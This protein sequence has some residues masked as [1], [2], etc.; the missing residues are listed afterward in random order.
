MPSRLLLLFLLIGCLLAGCNESAVR[1]QGHYE[2]PSASIPADS[3]L[4]WANDLKTGP[5]SQTRDQQ[6]FSAVIM[7]MYYN[8]TG[9]YPPA[10]QVLKSSLQ[11]QQESPDSSLLAMTNLMLGNAAKNLGE[12][13]EALNL[14]LRAL[15][16]YEHA[17]DKPS[18]A[19]VHAEIG[20][21]F[22]LKDDLPQ[23]TLHLNTALRL[24]DNHKNTVTYLVAL[25]T[26]ANVYGMQNKLDSALR[27]DEE[28]MAIS[29]QL[30]L[31]EQ[32]TTFLDN[33]ATCY[34]LRGQY[35]SARVFYYQCLDIDSATGNKKQVADSWM[36]IG[37][38]E[39]NLKHY[40]KAIACVDTAMRLAREAGYRRGLMQGWEE[41]S[42]IYKEQ[43]NYKEAI[44]AGEN[45]YNEKDSIVNERKETAIAAWKTIYET[46][47][48]DKEIG[49]QH[50]LIQ[51]KNL[52]IIFLCIL[53]PMALL[54]IYFAYRRNEIRK[55]KAY[56]ESL[57]AREQQAATDILWAGEKERRR[58]AQDLHDGVGQVLSAALLNLQALGNATAVLPK[59]DAQLINTAAQLV[60]NGASEIRQ[61]SHNMMPVILLKNG[62][63]FALQDF[64]NTMHYKAL[65]VHLSVDMPSVRLSE[66]TEV[67]L[68]RVIQE[69]VNNVVK[70]AQ[71]TRLD[72]SITHE[73]QHISIMIEDNGIG[74]KTK[75][76][77][78]SQGI[79]MDNIR[80]RINY[81]HGTVEWANASA[82]GG[83]TLVAIYIPVPE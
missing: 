61:I 3:L 2:I 39:Q 75:S 50:A 83:G 69:C 38:L 10:Q 17:G 20:R 21:V 24:L 54:V 81:L 63:I 82:D 52:I 51:Q 74:M 56:R 70:H 6:S 53:L 68:Y 1:Q 42:I 30:N 79:G 80:S 40:P 22:Q 26:L 11:M 31:P 77:A 65:S 37:V 23:S 5:G 32:I 4:R 14:Y 76:G 59:E 55:E 46:E 19:N 33:K 47:K 45:Y 73:E 12:Y 72:I 67:M 58:I 25:H 28:G 66:G 43:G 60:R 36:Q 7:G 64:V 15:D 35:D 16:Y 57:F 27:L 18:Q 13:P 41:L 29:R 9:A 8:K 48:K 62:L 71:A 44:K 34:S 78:A 49:L